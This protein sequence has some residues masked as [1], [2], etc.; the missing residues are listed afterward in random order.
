M[1]DYELA[2]IGLTRSDLSRVFK[3]GFS[4]DLYQRG[5][6]GRI[7]FLRASHH[8]SRLAISFSN[9]KFPGL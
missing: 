7:Q 2:D 5:D 1:S 3:P 6:L 4:Q 8:S 9:P